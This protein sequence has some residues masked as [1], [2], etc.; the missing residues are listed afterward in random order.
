LSVL[1]CAA[2]LED[3]ATSEA[4]VNI[5][6]ANEKIRA[7]EEQ[8]QAQVN[9]EAEAISLRAKLAVLESNSDVQRQKLIS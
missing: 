9:Q 1:T 8:L 6:R 2:S 3:A 4:L 5:R 7:L